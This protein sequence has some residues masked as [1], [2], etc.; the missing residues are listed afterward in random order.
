MH[1]E[2]SRLNL[3]RAGF[4]SPVKGQG[5]DSCSGDARELSLTNELISA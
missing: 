2:Q 3:R 4:L 1:G 5:K